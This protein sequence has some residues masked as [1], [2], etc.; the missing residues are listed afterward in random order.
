MKAT[1]SDTARTYVFRPPARYGFHA[2][3]ATPCPIFC[4]GRHPSS[5]IEDPVD[6][7]HSTFGD[8][9]ELP[10]KTPGGDVENCYAVEVYV[11]LRPYSLDP[12][13]RVPH[14]VV[15]VLDGAQ[16]APLTPDAFAEVIVRSA[17]QL[18]RMRQLHTVLVEAVAEH[19]GGGQ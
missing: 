8:A 5:G 9:L 11:N 15:A 2:E 1:A 12:A 17:V 7:S 6:V 16:T 19:Q 14:A 13:E 3:L 18:D 4:D 10:L